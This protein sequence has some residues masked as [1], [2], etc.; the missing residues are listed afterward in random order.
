MIE[1]YMGLC[2]L[3]SCIMFIKKM[4]TYGTHLMVDGLWF[5]IISH[6]DESMR[7]KFGLTGAISYLTINLQVPQWKAPFVCWLKSILGRGRYK[8][9]PP[10]K[11]LKCQTSHKTLKGSF[12]LCPSPKGSSFT[13]RTMHATFATFSITQRKWDLWLEIYRLQSNKFG[14]QEENRISF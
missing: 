14:F 6:L 10:R 5:K 9:Q 7:R 8:Q 4:Q 11:N 12:F 3:K 1:I 13:I 2:Q